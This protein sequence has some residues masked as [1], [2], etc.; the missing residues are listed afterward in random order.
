MTRDAFSAARPPFWPIS[1]ETVPL[2]REFAQQ[3]RNLPP[4][5]TERDL[6]ARRVAFL[7]ERLLAGLFHTPHWV[8]VDLNGR[9]MRANGQHSSEMLCQLSDAEFPQGLSVHYD[10]FGADSMD[11]VVLAFRQFDDRRSARTPLDISGAYQGN[12]TELSE[13]PRHTGKLGIEG[14]AFYRAKVLG[15]VVPKGDDIYGLFNDPSLYP[16]LL[17]LG[18]M[19]LTKSDLQFVPVVAAMFAT[20]SVDCDA[21]DVFWGEVAQ[22][23]RDYTEDTYPTNVLADW[24]HRWR[25]GEFPVKGLQVYQGCIYAWNAFRQDKT[26]RDIRSDVKKA[27]LRVL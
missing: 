22:G 9:K 10:V 21:A 20:Y 16:F 14:T 6:S 5:P 15:E 1:S 25:E 3:H 12:I 2:T 17:W 27:L 23:G 7:R 11:G 24:L 19:F 13:V 26:I 18:K 8:V 4:S